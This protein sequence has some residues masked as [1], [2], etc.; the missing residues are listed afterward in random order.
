MQSTTHV[1]AMATV[2]Q[3]V[4]LLVGLLERR[5]V[6]V[7]TGKKTKRVVLLDTGQQRQDD[8][9]EAH[10]LSQVVVAEKHT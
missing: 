4:H 3:T 7:A 5:S 9:Q 6:G 10:R 8:A 2:N 1:R